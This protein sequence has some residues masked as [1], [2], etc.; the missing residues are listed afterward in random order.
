MG[1][2]VTED[3]LFGVYSKYNSLLKCKVVRDKVRGFSKGF[4]YIS[5]SNGEDF[6]WAMRETNNIYIGKK[7]VTVKKAN[8]KDKIK[9]LS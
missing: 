9:S 8:W 6:L 2:E 5:F 3:H 7:R 4:A 1:N